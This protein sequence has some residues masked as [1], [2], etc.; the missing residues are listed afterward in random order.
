MKSNYPKKKLYF[1]LG[2]Q[3]H[4]FTHILICSIYIYMSRNLDSQS[5]IDLLTSI[6]IHWHP[7]ISME[8]NM[9][10]WM[11]QLVPYKSLATRIVGE[12]MVIPSKYGYIRFWPIAMWH[13]KLSFC[14]MLSLIHQNMVGLRKR[15][16]LELRCRGK[17]SC[18]KV[19]IAPSMPWAKATSGRRRWRCSKSWKN[20][21]WKLD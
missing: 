11:T 19:T 20:D 18:G 21:S 7:L 16:F 15:C 10:W 13:A 12:W 9:E 6:D 1:R 8:S 4:L 5:H 2:N 14:Q 3:Y 17:N